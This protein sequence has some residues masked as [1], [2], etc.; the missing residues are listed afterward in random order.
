MKADDSTQAQ[1]HQFGTFAGVF[2]PAILTILGVIMFLRSGYVVGAAGIRG[3]VLI[4][5]VAE[6]IVLVT[7]LSISAI[8]TNTPVGSGGAY[9]LI[10]RTL[11]A[12]FGGAIGLALFLAQALSV[13]FYLLGFTEALV[14]SFPVLRPWFL[15][16]GVGT[17]LILFV[18]NYVGA[19]WAIRSQYGV[20]AVL[21]VAIVSFLGGAALKF[22]PEVFAANWAPA[23]TT[24]DLSFWVLFA[25]YFP[26]VTG[27]LAGVNLS[28]DLKDPGR[29]LARGVLLAVAAGFAV[30]LAQMLLCGGSQARND[31]LER[32]FGMLLQNALGGW[33]LPVMAGV[34][35][36]TL[37]SAMGSLMA[38]PRVLQALARDGIVPG[39]TPF[40]RGTRNGDEPREAL[41]LT[42]LIT[43]SVMAAASD[44][45]GLKS[46]DLVASVVTMFFLCTYGMINLAAFVESFSANPS[47]R[48]QFRYFHWSLALPGVAACVVVMLLIDAVAACVAV[49][50]LAGLYV[51]ISRRVYRA[52]FGDARYGF[53]YSLVVRNLLRLRGMSSH[54]KNWRPTLL[55]L[56]GNPQTRP[57]LMRYGVWFEAQR[58]LVTLAEILSS[59]VPDKVI[60]K[61]AALDSMERFLHENRLAAFPEVVLAENLDEGIRLLVQAHSIGPIKPNTVL[62]GCPKARDRFGPFIRHLNDIRAAGKNVMAIVDGG[63]PPPGKE[64]RRIDLWW[65]GQENGSFMVVLAYLLTCNWEW[66]LARIR[67]LRLVANEAER[68][69]STQSLR[70]LVQAARMEAEVCVVVSTRPFQKV[71]KEH[72]SDADVIFLGFNLPDEERAEELYEWT[73]ALEAELPTTVLVHSIGE[74]NLLA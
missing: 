19:H 69:S 30:Y 57:T 59:D 37:S 25:V 58:G 24:P 74:A 41:W 1:R 72:S 55:V 14:Q 62:I 43:L 49:L 11:G 38:A 61:Q 45:A 56:S 15:W 17:A 20:M 51:L 39:L 18:I 70:Q 26:A 4:L 12:Q 9:F 42:L 52:A 73:Q 48:P 50:A 46:F 47:F 67:I 29:S 53:V 16:I 66:S 13:P 10:S 6:S 40:A 5:L 31:L 60:R 64:S 71:L 54:P 23:Y 63:L 28:G 7:A 36:A 34:F 2:T 21:A 44:G 22:S 35:A 68:E 27:I 8:A 32:P 65:R 33:A 3:A